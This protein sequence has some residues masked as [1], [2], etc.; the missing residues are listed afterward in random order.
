M[1]SNKIWKSIVSIALVLALILG[2]TASSSVDVHAKKIQIPDLYNYPLAAARSEL[3]NRGVDEENQLCIFDEEGKQWTQAKGWNWRVVYQRIADN[4]VYLYCMFGI[5]GVTGNKLDKA[6]EI[7]KQNGYTSIQKES[8]DEK[9]LAIIRDKNWTVTKVSE[10]NGTV[11]LYC[12]K[13][14]GVGKK[15]ANLAKEFFNS[16]GSEF[17]R[18]TLE[19]V[20]NPDHISQIQVFEESYFTFKDIKEKYKAGI[21][22]LNEWKKAI[23]QANATLDAIS[24]LDTSN[25]KT[26]EKA[27]LGFVVA[28]ITNDIV[29]AN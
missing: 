3:I 25:W 4:K 10:Y 27:Y 28:E 23:S 19:L 8:V 5:P 17:V 15:L 14:D 1:K 24:R 18:K 16:K 20:G 21:V 9:H 6:I 12:V 7:L 22:T 11:Y 2:I 29:N 13:T 26:V